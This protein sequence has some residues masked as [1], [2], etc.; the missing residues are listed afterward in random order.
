MFVCYLALGVVTDTI[1][2]AALGSSTCEELTGFPTY[3]RDILADI[4]K[5]SLDLYGQNGPCHSL[6]IQIRDQYWA[7]HGVRSLQCHLSTEARH[8]SIDYRAVRAVT[9]L[10]VRVSYRP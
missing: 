6:H 4:F 10:T 3:A 8:L 7:V 5:N 9:L 2:S 1:M